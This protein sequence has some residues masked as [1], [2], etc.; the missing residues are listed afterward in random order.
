MSNVSFITKQRINVNG[1]EF[2]YKDCIKAVMISFGDFSSM[3]SIQSFSGMRTF[4]ES[5]FF[6]IFLLFI[7][8]IGA[9]HITKDIQDVISYGFSFSF[10]KFLILF[11]LF[12][13]SSHDFNVSLVAAFFSY[14]FLYILLNIQ[15]RYCILPLFCKKNIEEFVSDGKDGK[16]GKDGL[17][18][19]KIE[20]K[21]E[22]ENN[23]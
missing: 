21:D 5:K 20:R 16:D 11:A 23:Y 19:N 14:I 4:I 6:Q 2:F 13:T 9:S 1:I 7:I 17:R 15:S 22:E 3:Q 10:M 12:F 8:Q 18:L